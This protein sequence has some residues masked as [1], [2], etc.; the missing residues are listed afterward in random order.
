[1]K[2]RAEDQRVGQDCQPPMITIEGSNR[3]HT[4]DLSYEQRVVASSGSPFSD[5]CALVSLC[6]FGSAASNCIE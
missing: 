4:V 5:G 2:R 6:G 1:M 3:A